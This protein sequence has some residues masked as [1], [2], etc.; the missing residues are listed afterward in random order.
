MTVTI[1]VGGQQVTGH[2]DGTQL[3]SQCLELSGWMFL[4]VARKRSVVTLYHDID[5]LIW[6]PADRQST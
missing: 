3:V 5:K 4:H 2:Q 1:G 6:K